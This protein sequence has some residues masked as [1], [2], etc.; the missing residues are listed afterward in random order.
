[1]VEGSSVEAR[2]RSRRRAAVEGEDRSSTLERR[3][4]RG[5]RRGAPPAG[6]GSD[7]PLDLPTGSDSG[8][9]DEVRGGTLRER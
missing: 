8:G 2:P 3:R 4:G 5:G 6:G 1:V 7:A 9:K